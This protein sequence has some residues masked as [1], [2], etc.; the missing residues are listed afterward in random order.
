MSPVRR[1]AAPRKRPAAKTAVGAQPGAVVQKDDAGVRPDAGAQRRQSQHEALKQ[2]AIEEF[3]SSL[4]GQSG[5]DEEGLELLL[6]AFRDAVQE[7]SLD[8][9]FTPLDPDEVARTLNGLV[10]DGVLVEEDRN[11]IAR[12]FESALDPLQDAE[13]KIA[14]EFAQRVERDGEAKAREWLKTQNAAGD[15]DARQDPPVADVAP[16]SRQAITQSR[17]RRPRGPPSR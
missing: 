16:H 5:M 4:R 1:P 8:A 15:A 11:A 9:E 13:L 10:E 6:N 7:A 12:Q 17:S 2:R 14:L 3:E